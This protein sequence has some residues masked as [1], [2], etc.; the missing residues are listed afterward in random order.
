VGKKRVQKIHRPVFYGEGGKAAV[1]YE[2][3]A[4]HQAWRCGVEVEAGRGWLGNV[5][6]RDLIL[7]SLM[8]DVDH[9]VVA[10]ANE[11]WSKTGGKDVA[12][13]DYD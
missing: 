4:Y 10:L 12:S 7:A 11:Y 1:R 6:Y 13:K 8:V 2:I 9:L 5:F 3:D